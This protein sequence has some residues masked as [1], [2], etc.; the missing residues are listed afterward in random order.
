M[1]WDLIFYSTLAGVCVGLLAGLFGVGG[2]ILVVPVLTVLFRKMGM[3]ESII[4][5]SAIGTSL[6]TIFFTSFSSFYTH[7]LK[8]AVLWRFVV[9]VSP[10]IILG[11]YLGSLFASSLKSHVLLAIF[12]CFAYIFS[13]RLILSSFTSASSTKGPTS[14][15]KDII[16]PYQKKNFG[17]IIS[18]SLAGIAIGFSS[19]L[20]G[21]GGGVF[22]SAYLLYLR[23]PIHLAIGT[24]SAIGFP[25]AVSATISY[26]IIGWNEPNLMEYSLG[27]VYLP[28]LLGIVAGSIPSAILGAR[29]SHR[30]DKN[31]LRLFF[32]CFLF[33]M[34]LY[35]SYQE[36]KILSNSIL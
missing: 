33:I 21:I 36:Y 26:I 17:T 12:I 8:K 29:L 35:M 20:V 18:R 7:H 6:A 32:G 25:I 23:T 27:F 9:I 34:A 14:P 5:H 16:Y 31:K 2:G 1:D 30:L 4:A 15:N 28:A 10:G 24:S 3:E 19:A 11:S 22:S 13:F